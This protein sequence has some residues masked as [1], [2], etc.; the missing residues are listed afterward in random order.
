MQLPSIYLIK[1]LKNW[2]SKKTL[3]VATIPSGIIGLSD[4]QDL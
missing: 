3:K 4:K 1:V 2:L